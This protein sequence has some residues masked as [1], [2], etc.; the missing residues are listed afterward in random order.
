MMESAM[1]AKFAVLGA[2]SSA[3][4]DSLVEAQ[5]LLDA[6]LGSQNPEFTPSGKKILYVLPLEEIENRF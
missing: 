5:R 6:L 2:S 3:P 4:L 1:A